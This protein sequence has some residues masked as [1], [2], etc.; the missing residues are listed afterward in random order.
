MT[1]GHFRSWELLLLA[2]LV[3]IVTMNI[4]RS[5]YYLGVG[6]IVNL[7]QLSIE[8][9]IVAL[10]LTL[11][12]INAEIDL[13]VASIMG[14]AAA[15][16]AWLFQ[17]GVPLPLAILAA[18]VAG[19]LAG[20]NNGFWIA[21]LGL[22]SL[23]VT[24][25]GL[26]GY[27]GIARILLEDRAV[28]NYPEWFNALGQQPLFGPLTLSIVIF[29]ILLI[30]IAV[31]L[32]RS[33]LG[34]LIYVMGNSLETARY[35]GVRVKPIK[36][37]LFVASGV[38]AALA[39]LLYAARL[40]SVR[41]D[42]AQGFE[43]DIITMVLLGGVSIFGGSGNLIGVGLSIL[44]ILN[45]RNGMG[46]ANITGNTQTSVIGAL[47]ILS[48]LAPNLVQMVHGAWKGRTA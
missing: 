21:Y 44:V 27:R 17:L 22:P 39:G 12:I 36:L 15:V 46:L 20:L 38:V 45:L 18:M 28:G 24:L 40:G 9:I 13:S 42:I 31:V 34:R 11:V 19:A 43:L 8:K 30:A 16:M 48:V 33:A 14:L 35:S 1:L 37:V 29:L 47:L 23:A 5:P 41:G 10:M 32:H 25:A 6:N 2:V 26:I 7:F 3:V 4:A